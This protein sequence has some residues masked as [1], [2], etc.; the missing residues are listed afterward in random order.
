MGR[1]NKGVLKYYVLK[2]LFYANGDECGISVYP[3]PQ[4]ETHI[5]TFIGGELQ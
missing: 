3:K 5:P 2:Y 4:H 1:F